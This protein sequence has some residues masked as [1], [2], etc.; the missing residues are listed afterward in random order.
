MTLP[1]NKTQPINN[2]AAF[3]KYNRK[4]LQLTQE[5]L[6]T[7]SGLGIH[8]IRNLE[9]GSLKLSL[10]KVNQLFR[11][12]GFYLS[13]VPNTTISS[14]QIWCTY[15]NKAVVITKTNKTQ[16]LGFLM[17]EVRDEKG[18]IVAWKVSP[19]PKTID[20]HEKKDETQWQTVKQN[21][22]AEINFQK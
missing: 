21:E 22:I 3:V 13:P 20:W 17:C 7:M 6:A 16:V 10:D 15:L 11:F 19:N 1:K 12:F 5:Q 2:I 8:F 18:N 4:K 9:Q 14:W